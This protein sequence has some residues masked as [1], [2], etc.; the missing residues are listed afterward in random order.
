VS[1]GLLTGIG[2]AI[3]ALGLE[4]LGHA[5]VGGGKLTVLL[6]MF[7]IGIGAGMPWGLMDG[8]AMGV[9]PKERAGMA[10]GIFNT[11]RVAGEGLTL[12]VVSAILAA[13]VGAN[14]LAGP[15]TRGATAAQVSEA[16][17]RIAA[18]DLAGAA[19]LL[20]QLD[21]ALLVGAYGDAFHVLVHV[22]AGVTLL[23]ALAAFALL[24]GKAPAL[25]QRDN[26]GVT[27]AAEKKAA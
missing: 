7:L 8:L 4:W 3:A 27:Q 22:L 1:A 20:P 18:G 12:A 17:Q 25:E 24:G 19:A 26:E 10:T 16:S 6:P 14:L 15:H 2:F 23:A 5:G 13:A 21:H 11:S 9:V